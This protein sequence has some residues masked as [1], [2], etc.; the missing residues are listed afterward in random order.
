MFPSINQ[1]VLLKFQFDEEEEAKLKRERVLD[2]WNRTKVYRNGVYQKPPWPF[3]ES[4]DENDEPQDSH[5]ENQSVTTNNDQEE[6]EGGS[7]EEDDV[8]DVGSENAF[9]ANENDANA[10]DMDLDVENENYYYQYF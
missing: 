9:F 7:D 1:N 5:S 10:V 8:W 4:E 3:S 2:K 6:C